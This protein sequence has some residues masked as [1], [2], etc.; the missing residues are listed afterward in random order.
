MGKIVKQKK[1]NEFINKE[2]LGMT[3]VLFSAFAFFCLVTGDAVFYP[4]G[5]ILQKFLLGVFGFFSYPFFLAFFTGGLLMIMGKHA[6]GA[7]NK[8]TAVACIVLFADLFLLLQYLLNSPAGNDFGGYVSACYRA[9][10]D[11]VRSSTVGGAMFGIIVYPVFR[12]LSGVGSIILY[13]FVAILSLAVVFR[14]ILF[15]KFADKNDDGESDGEEGET[16]LPR[17]KKETARESESS[18]DDASARQEYRPPVRENYA[19]GNNFSSFPG[20]RRDKRKLIVGEDRFEFK[21]D[22]PVPAREND[23]IDLFAANNGKSESISTYGKEYNKDFEEKLKYIKTPKKIEPETYGK[24]IGSSM[25]RPAGSDA[26]GGEQIDVSEPKNDIYIPQNFRKAME[27]N[28]GQK[29]GTG[30]YDPDADR[31]ID[32]FPR[33]NGIA[34]G[35][36][37]A[38]GNDGQNDRPFGRGGAGVSYSPASGQREDPLPDILS[39]VVDSAS[40]DNFVDASSV[41]DLSASFKGRREEPQGQDDRSAFRREDEP[42]GRREEPSVSADRFRRD[43]SSKADIPENTGYVPKTPAAEPP[44]APKK[45]EPADPK[46]DGNDKS[47]QGEAEN[48]FDEMP[49]NFRY[50]AP[51]LDLFKIYANN[52]DY[53]KIQQFKQEKASAILK[54]LKVLGGVNAEIVNIVHGPTITRFDLA[55]PENVSVKAVTKLSEDLNLRLATKNSIRITTIP[56]TPYIGIEIPNEVKSTVGLRDVL[57]SDPFVK[58]KKSSLTFAIGKDIV[59]NPVVADITKMPHLLI[60]GSTGTGKSVCLNTL[61]IS[62]IAKYS[63]AELR[64]IIVD[65]KQVEFTVFSGIPHMLFDEIICDAPKAIAMLNWA[66][67]EMEARYSKLRAALVHNIEEYNDQIDPTKERKM[68]KI[69]IIIDEF[70]DLM[71]VDKKNIEDKIAR[72]AQ[73]ARAA[74]MFLILATQRP[75]VN[76]MEGS[77]KTNFTSRMAFKMSNAVDSQTILGEGGAEKLLGAGDMLYRTSTMPAVERAQ[78]AFIDMS[79]IKNVVKYVK[80]NN[81]SYFNDSA[82]R[83]INEECKPQIEE[84]SGKAGGAEIGED[85]APDEYIN[86]LRL[87]VQMGNI[88]ISMLQRKFSFGFPKAGKIVDWMERNG[89]I[90]TSQTGKQKQVVMTKE[91][92]EEKYGPL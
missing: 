5:G 80:E 19:E 55:I 46:G 51:P 39:D 65:P 28:P 18:Y 72:I 74:G 43:E 36:D 38:G 58:A 32:P 71:S 20:D 68:P 49:L 26:F 75:S 82:L 83:A 34:G 91:Q 29:Y 1:E 73:K 25:F 47:G 52:D 9:A 50:K 86:S 11:G 61:L 10:A 33:G 66:V 88:S 84:V 23:G 90:V 6:D 30:Y 14:K 92:F 15:R 4:V 70:A 76:I 53:D 7:D 8:T 56:G 81:V 62:L 64:F 89:Y 16:I 42:F 85:N 79:E 77:I 69:V 48:P 87:A 35:I 3:L 60:A 78:G 54:T 27:D 44:R 24:P 57:V 63:P 41:S 45:E 12:G 17:K 22:E 67:K 31:G 59:G 13:V 37:Y 40:D 21:R 2:L